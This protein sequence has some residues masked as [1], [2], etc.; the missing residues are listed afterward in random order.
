MRITTSGHTMVT[1]VE[2]LH[3]AS[4]SVEITSIWYIVVH[5]VVSSNERMNAIWLVESDRYR[6]CGRRDTLV[7]RLTEYNE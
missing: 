1:C 5:N 4:V 3:T 6:Y 2:N 7:H